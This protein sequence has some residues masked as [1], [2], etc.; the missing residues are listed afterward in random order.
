MTTCCPS[1]DDVLP[2]SPS[3]SVNSTTHENE[4]CT[5]VSHNYAN[6]L[7]NGVGHNGIEL[8]DITAM[9]NA[10]TVNNYVFSTLERELR[11]MNDRLY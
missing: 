11:N 1:Q 8:S 9:E 5:L 4:K 10:K 3:R 7:D 2:R 6:T